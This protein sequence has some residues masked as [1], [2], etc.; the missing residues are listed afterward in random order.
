MPPSRFTGLETDFL[1][2]AF[3]HVLSRIHYFSMRSP[4]WPASQVTATPYM[5]LGKKSKFFWHHVT[6]AAGAQQYPRNLQ[7]PGRRRAV[8]VIGWPQ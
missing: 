3:I 5:N 2:H 4:A 7:W 6:V 1:L 8:N